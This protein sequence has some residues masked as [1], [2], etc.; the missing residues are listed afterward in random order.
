MKPAMTMTMNPTTLRRVY[1]N[2]FRVPADQDA[3]TLPEMLNAVTGAVY[4]ELDTKLDG[5]T[6]TNRKPMI[7]SLRRNLQ[8]ELTDR[9]IDVALGTRGLPRAIQTLAMSHLK[10]VN[11]KIESIMDRAD[12]GQVD[13]Y[14]LVHLEDLNERI[15]R[16]LNA[17]QL[18]R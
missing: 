17:I 8:S 13:E 14:T 16:A 11:E 10:R 2:E 9:L 1:D 5:V 6:F 15:G 18:A 12:T 3:L 4:T 7:S